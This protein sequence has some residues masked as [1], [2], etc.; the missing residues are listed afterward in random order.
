MAND[1]Q[2]LFGQTFGS[3]VRDFQVCGQCFRDA[4]A[5]SRQER[6]ILNAI[7]TQ[8]RRRRSCLGP[9]G[10]AEK[11]DTCVGTIDPDEQGA[12]SG[13]SLVNSRSG[14]P[15][16]F[17][18]IGS[19][20]DDFLFTDSGTQAVSGLFL[21]SRCLPQD[22]PALVCG[23]YDG[24]RNGMSGVLFDR[25]RQGKQCVLVI[26]VG[27]IN[28]SHSKFSRRERA[29]FV[30]D[31]RINIIGGLEKAYALDENAH[32]GCCCERG[33]HRCRASQDKGAWDADHD[34]RN[35]PLQITGEE[36]HKASYQK[37]QRHIVASV[38]LS[39]TNDGRARLLCFL[40]DIFDPAK[41]CLRTCLRNFDL[42]QPGQIRCSGENRR[43]WPD[44][45]GNGLPRNA[46][47]IHGG[48]PGKHRS[49]SG[50]RVAGT[51]SHNISLLQ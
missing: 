11:N 9:Q 39:E 33:Y 29:C 23:R 2:L 20:D 5:I 42:D 28:R 44:F 37:N 30:E 18:P 13:K 41:D 16:F 50:N 27:T 4:E 22:K 46:R 45:G 1:F 35:S 12:Q 43:T 6:E 34:N 40:H 3:Y 36:K 19:S 10:V 8:C 15:S 47:L 51:H 7:G 25:T 38:F 24:P 21:H 14:N 26:A 17:E 48:K 49:V 31:D 32:A